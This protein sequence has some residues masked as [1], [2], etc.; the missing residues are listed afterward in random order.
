MPAEDSLCL[1]LPVAPKCS[2]AQPVTRPAPLRPAPLHPSSPPL[3]VVKTGSSWVQL[4]PFVQRS[5]NQIP[6]SA[7]VQVLFWYH[8]HSSLMEILP[9]KLCVV[10]VSGQQ[11][12]YHCA[13]QRKKGRVVTVVVRMFCFSGDVK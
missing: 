9:K 8:F 7:V 10:H 5:L 12:H 13:T 2:Q 11:P 3:E 4:G 1:L 6:K